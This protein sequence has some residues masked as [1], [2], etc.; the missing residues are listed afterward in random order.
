MRVAVTLPRF[1]VHHF[2]R[3]ARARCADA[4]NCLCSPRTAPPP[5][6]PA[7]H[8]L[9]P[10]R[11][12]GAPPLQIARARHRQQA[13]HPAHRVIARDAARSRRTSPRL[14]REIRRRFFYDF[15]V[16]LGTGQFPA[17][18]RILGFQF[19]DRTLDRHRRNRPTPTPSR[20]CRTQFVM[21]DCGIPSRSAVALPPLDSANLTASVLNSSVYRRFGTAPSFPS[22]PPVHQ[23]L[24]NILMYVKPGQDQL[25][26]LA[27]LRTFMLA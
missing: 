22:R 11:S 14:L 12:A 13:A 19:R 20:L 18:P 7:A 6:H 1:D 26:W 3:A 23:K 21:V 2:A 24:T 4:H 8:W 25:Q 27:C 16:K 5:A 10:G 9:A 15:Q 17:Q